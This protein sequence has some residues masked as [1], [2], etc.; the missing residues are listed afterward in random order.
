[1]DFQLGESN[2]FSYKSLSKRILR[3][4]SLKTTINI[5]SNVRN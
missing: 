3:R 5:E 1:M 4:V 2:L